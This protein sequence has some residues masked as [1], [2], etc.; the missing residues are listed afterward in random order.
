[1]CVQNF[2]GSVSVMILSVLYLKTIIL[3]CDLLYIFKLLYLLIDIK[4]SFLGEEGEDG[5]PPILFC[6][7]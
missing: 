1:M 5:K 3:H 6:S 7:T 2:D 4:T